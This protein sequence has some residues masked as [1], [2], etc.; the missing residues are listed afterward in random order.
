MFGLKCRIAAG[1]YR[2]S[3]VSVS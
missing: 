2:P 3:R 1:G